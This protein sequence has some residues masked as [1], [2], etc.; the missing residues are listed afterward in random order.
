MQT[1]LYALYSNY[2]NYYGEWEKGRVGV[3]PVFIVD[4]LKP[5]SSSHRQ[6]RLRA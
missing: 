2:E 6:R 3:P 1:A 4:D 5:G